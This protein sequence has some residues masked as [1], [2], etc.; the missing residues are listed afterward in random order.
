MHFRSSQLQL[1]DL[2]PTARILRYL[3]TRHI[4]K[5]VEP[6]VFANNRISTLL[7]KPR[8]LKEIESKSVD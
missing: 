4:F 5:E 8:S 3:S 6:D 2:Y 1:P 7:V